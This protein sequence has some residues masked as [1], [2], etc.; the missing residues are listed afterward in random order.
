MTPVTLDVLV[1][2][3][4][5][6]VLCGFALRLRFE[7]DRRRYDLNL[8]KIAAD[9]RLEQERND[10]YRGGSV[11]TSGA[12]DEVDDAI[13]TR[14]AEFAVAL[15]EPLRLIEASAASL[16]EA[17]PDLSAPLKDLEAGVVQ[18]RALVADYLARP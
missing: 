8:R 2:I 16:R 1:G 11:P 6:A 15:D 14:L 17:D 18:C 4:A 9:F 10:L 5:L 13:G 7:W 3:L 12:A